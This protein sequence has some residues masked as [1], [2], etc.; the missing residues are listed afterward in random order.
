MIF[1]HESSLFPSLSLSLSLSLSSCNRPLCLCER[2]RGSFLFVLF[3]LCLAHWASNS[4]SR[5]TPCNSY[6]AFT[7]SPRAARWALKSPCWKHLIKASYPRW[8]NRE[9][10]APGGEN[11]AS[12]NWEGR[13]S[14]SE[15]RIRN[16]ITKKDRRQQSER[17]RKGGRGKE[18][19]KERER[20]TTMTAGVCAWRVSHRRVR[21]QPHRRGSGAK[22]RN[23]VSSPQRMQA[24]RHLLN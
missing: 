20:K 2:R 4:L 18:R 17:G 14:V 24:A 8:W 16:E 1:F 6:A 11:D 21:E 22:L 13:E 5:L 10:W 23:I 3:R 19:E 12:Q 9:N 15:S 7:R